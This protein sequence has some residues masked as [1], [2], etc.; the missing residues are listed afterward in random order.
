MQPSFSNCLPAG[1]LAVCAAVVCLLV[2]VG[3]EA[4]VSL[5]VSQ[6]RRLARQID[7]FE[8]VAE[9]A[10]ERGDELWRAGT[11]AHLQRLTERHVRLCPQEKRDYAR[12]M[13]K[14]MGETAKKAGKAFLRY[15]TFG[16]Y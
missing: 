16:A 6:C 1:R 5:N 11:M 2:A 8:S 7:R 3:A 9:M 14:W 10:E 4:S 12:I 15:L 13:A